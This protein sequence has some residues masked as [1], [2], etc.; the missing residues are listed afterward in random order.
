MDAGVL[1][2]ADVTQLAHVLL[3]ALGEAAMLLANADDPQ[4]ER[5]RVEQTTLT[6]L[7][8]IRAQQ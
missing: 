6:L 8:G 2:P 3:G 1:R 7:E 5:E 4:A